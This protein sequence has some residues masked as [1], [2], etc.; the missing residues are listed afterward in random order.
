MPHRIRRANTMQPTVQAHSQRTTRTHPDSV[1]LHGE[2]DTGHGHSTFTVTAHAHGTPQSRHHHAH[3]H[4]VTAH[5]HGEHEDTGHGL[6]TD[7][8]EPGQLLLDHRLALHPQVLQRAL[9]ALLVET[10]TPQ[11]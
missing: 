10:A 7:A 2:Q 5:L 4:A 11:R 1:H 8:L 6:G 3:A 9:A